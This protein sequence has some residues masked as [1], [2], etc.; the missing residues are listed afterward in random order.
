MEKTCIACGVPTEKRGQM[1]RKFASKFFIFI[2]D[3]I[4]VFIELRKSF[5]MKNKTI[6]SFSMFSCFVCCFRSWYDE[7]KQYLWNI[8][9]K[10]ACKAGQFSQMVWKNSREL[11]IGLGRTRNGKVI[12]VASYFPRG[13][14]IGQFLHN[15]KRI[16]QT[17]AAESASEE[18]QH[19]KVD[20]VS[21]EMSA[22][23]FSLFTQVIRLRAL[24]P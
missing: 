13:N 19:Q 16:N 22:T 6:K 24:K 9:P 21:M 20:F 2:F 5:D 12:V 15:V 23:F 11:G 7:V 1:Q 18:R 14:I 3:T 17:V 8:E 4:S 10:G